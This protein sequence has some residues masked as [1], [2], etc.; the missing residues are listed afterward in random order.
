MH[1]CTRVYM[2]A[3]VYTRVCICVHTCVHVC[4]QEGPQ[5]VQKHAPGSDQGASSMR[6]EKA[7]LLSYSVEHGARVKNRVARREG[8]LSWGR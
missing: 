2:C 6:L 3:C 4:A 1:M 7:F 5:E 8:C